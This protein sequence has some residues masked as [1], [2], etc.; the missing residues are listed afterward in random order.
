MFGIYL[1]FLL[2]STL[3][4]Y[5]VLGVSLKRGIW[6]RVL[7]CYLKILKIFLFRSFLWPFIDIYIYDFGLS[8]MSFV[9][10]SSIAF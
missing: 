9:F 2:F 8:F 3:L 5:F 1:L 7:S 6:L 4:N 10:F